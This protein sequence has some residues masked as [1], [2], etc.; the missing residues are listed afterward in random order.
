MKIEN[1]GQI[2]E[3]E[4]IQIISEYTAPKFT[5]GQILI[6]RV[7][8]IQGDKVMLKNNEGRLFMA[9]M[10][11]DLGLS[12]GDNVEV[13]ANKNGSGYVLHL[14]DVESSNKQSDSLAAARYNIPGTLATIKANPGLDPKAAAFLI[15]NNIPR[16]PENIATLAQIAKGDSNLGA[17]LKSIVSGL[18]SLD[19]SAQA[20]AAPGMKA[21]QAKPGM[22][23]PEVHYI[24]EE[25]T[26]QPDVEGK[27]TAQKPGQT[28]QLTA[29]GAEAAQ[30]GASAEHIAQS[31]KGATEAAGALSLNTGATQLKTPS[32]VGQMAGQ[33]GQ[34]S[35]ASVQIPAEQ[36]GV[37]QNKVSGEAQQ[38]ILNEDISLM[39][40]KLA[41]EGTA[42]LEKDIAAFERLLP[43][44]DGNFRHVDKKEITDKILDLFC[45]PDKQTGAE[46]KKAVL[47]IPD[48]LGELKL[49]LQ[50]ADKQDIGILQ[51]AEQ[52]Q[53]QLEL[54]AEAKRFD[55][56]Q[57][58]FMLKNGPERTAE[59]YVY[60]RKRNQ[61]EAGEEGL[62]VLIALDTQYIGRVETLLKTSGKSLSVEFRL[63]QKEIQPEIIKRSKALSKA[64][65]NAGYT[66][67]S[68]KITGL[69]TR[70][71]V[72]NAGGVLIPDAGVSSGNIDVHV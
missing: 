40:E 66:L 17:L 14:L 63:E 9:Q 71:N 44:T 12:E 46:F 3:V 37:L 52:A 35:A 36:A 58:P 48:K 30:I 18:V 1:I 32:N 51:K 68:L 45:K 8:N 34:A 72:L 41:A 19:A 57:I 4:Q 24:I 23:N 13:A 10:Q 31:P 67:K 38:V 61:K 64:L 29:K 62:T 28:G 54:L 60:R 70:T 22:Q 7:E 25:N 11:S 33:A 56:I 15:E 42:P 5:E 47:D 69:E 6:A 53:K 27:Q 59:L 43:E 21:T 55:C 50:H 20:A 16:T 65:E 39:K 2:K 26:A 49:L